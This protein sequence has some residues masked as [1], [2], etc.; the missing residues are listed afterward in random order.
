MAKG[1]KPWRDS[2]IF[3][4]QWLSVQSRNIEGLVVPVFHC[5]ISHQRDIQVARAP[6]L[7]VKW[8][9]VF[10][11]LVCNHAAAQRDS[12]SLGQTRLQPCAEFFEAKTI[13]IKRQTD[14]SGFYFRVV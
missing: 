11:T 1:I 6:S 3:V 7:F 5:L 9:A 8:S 13:S 10:P 4:A 2:G 12:G 14:N